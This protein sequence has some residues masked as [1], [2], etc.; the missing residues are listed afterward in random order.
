MATE[1]EER[2]DARAGPASEME[3]P[4]RGDAA[5]GRG[6]VLPVDEADGV[7]DEL[8]AWFLTRAER[9]GWVYTS[10]LRQ[11]VNSLY[12]D[13]DYLERRKGRSRKTAYDYAV[14]R[15]MKAT[16]WAIR[17]LV[18]FVPSAEKQCSQAAQAGPQAAQAPQRTGAGDVR[19][20]AELERRAQA[21]LG[22]ARATAAGALSRMA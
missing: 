8:Q 15:D 5:A 14:E 6:A 16:S 13:R 12:R 3:E 4:L 10:V 2:Q 21:W 9:E 19:G 1:Q 17:A 18:R 20:R 11:M 7:L 22:R